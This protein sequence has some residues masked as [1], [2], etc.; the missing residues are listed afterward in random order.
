VLQ[1]PAVPCGNGVD[2]EFER[3]APLEPLFLKRR[4]KLLLVFTAFLLSPFASDW[5]R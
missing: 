1:D 2:L 3:S 4:R 5:S